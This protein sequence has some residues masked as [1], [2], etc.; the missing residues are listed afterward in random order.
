M[1]PP[2]SSPAGAT[3]L[4]LLHQFSSTDGSDPIGGLVV[5]PNTGTLY[6]TTPYGG[7]TGNG[8]VFSLTPPAAGTAK[9][10][11]Q[12]IYTFKGNAD[13]SRPQ[14]GLAINPAGTALYGTTQTGST[15]CSCGTVFRLLKPGKPGREW[16]K[17]LFHEFSGDSFDGVVPSSAPFLD[18]ASSELYG[19]TGSIGGSGGTIFRLSPVDGSHFKVIYNPAQNVGD[20][21]GYHPQ[22]VVV[23]NGIV[24]GT[25]FDGA[26]AG[27]LFQFSGQG[28]KILHGFMGPDGAYPQTPPIVGSDG[29]LYGT[30][31]EGGKPAD[32]PES[33]GCG[34]VWKQSPGASET[35]LHSMA[36]FTQPRDGMNPNA[37][38][39]LDA[40]TGTLYGATPAGGLG[41]ECGAV[42]GSCGTVFTID[43]NGK[44]RVIWE[45][46][47]GGP[48][49]PEGQLVF[50]AGVLFGTSYDG[51]KPCPDQHYIGCGTVWMLTP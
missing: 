31:Y 39:V 10:Q 33:P 46:P 51:G 50:R 7:G 21:V 36:F 5:D 30:T 15:L 19:T 44:Y 48:A 8:T 27:T 1:V 45:F 38:L 40:H 3:T 26:Y 29:T 6:G 23:R 14:N 24:Y 18:S 12:T 49:V 25:A 47:K 37:P 16:G 2:L 20:F 43:G 9:W 32:C 22:G 42:G 13:G 4:T 34:V 11:F 17:T 35:K 28:G 41:T